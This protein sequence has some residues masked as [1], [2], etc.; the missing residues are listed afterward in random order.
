MKDETEKPLTVPGMGIIGSPIVYFPFEKVIN[1]YRFASRGYYASTEYPALPRL[2]V[3]RIEA[4]DDGA[5][6]VRLALYPPCCC[7]HNATWT[8]SRI[9]WS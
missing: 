5:N 9:S 4:Q 3:D 6:A 7:L 2:S 8:L 1:E